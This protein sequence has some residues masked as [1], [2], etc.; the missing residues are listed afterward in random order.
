[1]SS[2][3]FEPT[4]IFVLAF[5]SIAIMIGTVITINRETISSNFKLATDTLSRR[6]SN[7][8]T[9]KQ[10]NIDAKKA[11]PKETVNQI[12]AF[13]A[14]AVD[15]SG[16]YQTVVGNNDPGGSIF[17][18]SD[19]G[20]TWK[21]I[22]D[23]Q[24]TYTDWFSIAMSGDGK[25]Q[26]SL[27]YTHGA[28]VSVMKSTTYGSTWV[29][30]HLNSIGNQTFTDI[31][32]NQDGSIWTVVASLVTS[33]NYYGG[34]GYIYTSRDFG[35]S[36]TQSNAPMGSWFSVELSA[37]GQYQVAIQQVNGKLF[38]S[39]NYGTDWYC[40]MDNLY[41]SSIDLSS[42]GQYVTAVVRNGLVYVSKDYGST[43]KVTDSE[44]KVWTNV[45]LSDSGKY[46]V[47]AVNQG[48]IYTSND[49]GSTWQLSFQTPKSNFYYTAING[50]GTII[51]VCDFRGII[52]EI[53]S[54]L[55]TIA[56]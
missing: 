56:V 14:I 6:L 5:V 25:I 4:K 13:V 8:V 11:D 50:D 16:Q 26:A 10:I 32:M 44:K 40:T 33:F 18:S 49:Y 54:H 30:V 22:V 38:V 37:T 41:F 36:F 24:N 9:W 47:V 51:A 29:D 48:A 52:Y 27:K 28:D 46:Q 31:A 7:S 55:T 1:M 17:T 20:Q 53:N 2:T 42:S 19:Y 15:K 35:K 45:A 12:N 43:F 21:L 23:D 3:F 34:G 39:S